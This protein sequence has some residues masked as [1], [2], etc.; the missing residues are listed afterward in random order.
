MT[1]LLAAIEAF[2]ID[3]GIP[4]LTFEAR[5]ARENRWPPAHA[6]RAVAEYRRFVYLAATAGHPVTPSDAV[7]QVWHLHLTYTRSY[8]DGLCG[9][10]L[11]RPLHHGPTR[12]GA[13][14]TARF[15]DQYE[16]TLA[17]YRTA[18]GEAPPADLWPPAD[19]RFGPDLHFT[20]VNTAENWVVPKPS[21]RRAAT[22]WAVATA[23]A[24]F[25]A[26]C[27]TADSIPP[28]SYATIFALLMVLLVAA[29][30][31][32]HVLRACLRGPWLTGGTDDRR[33]GAEYPPPTTWSSGGDVGCGGGDGG[34][35]GGDGGGG[36]GG[37]G[38][39]GGCGGCG[40]CGG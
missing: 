16:R 38:C 25:A 3:D 1:A 19:T 13:G 23:V 7:D 21:L 14:E 10:V 33:D 32:G 24:L 9:R 29:G 40:G 34:D 35:G 37:G 36:C 18:F 11:G 15:R 6:R 5:L 26:G 28:L 8:W 27:G 22:A 4:A 39:G 30:V 20:R 17:A 31:F 12:G 2:P